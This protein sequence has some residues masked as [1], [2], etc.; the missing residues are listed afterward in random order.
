MK[1]YSVIGVDGHVDEAH[2]DWQERLP[3]E[4]QDWAPR[5]FTD[6]DGSRYYFVE[7]KLF[8][9]PGEDWLGRAP[10]SEAESQRSKVDTEAYNR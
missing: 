2:P 3:A 10:Y 6:K 4:F 7:G 5:Y 9:C 1:A 8:T